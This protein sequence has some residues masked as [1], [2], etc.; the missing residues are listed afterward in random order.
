MIPAATL[1]GLG[2]A[3]IIGLGLFGVILHPEPLRKVLAFNLLG[4]GVFVLFGV[5]ARRGGG[6]L[7]GVPFGDPVPQALIIT[8]LVVAFAATVLAVALVLR[9]AQADWT[10]ADDSHRGGQGQVPQPSPDAAPDT[11]ADLSPGLPPDQAR[12]PSPRAVGPAA[13]SRSVPN[14]SPPAAA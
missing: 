10:H 13:A 6:R 11:S 3:L 12:A 4:S 7:E 8:G 9:L 5:V 2:A 14:A 1:F